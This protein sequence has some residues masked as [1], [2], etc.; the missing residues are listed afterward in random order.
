MNSFADLT[1]MLPILVESPDR[2]RNVR[3]V[4]P[5]LVHCCPDATFRIQ[6]YPS[7][8]TAKVQ[9]IVE[10]Q[11]AKGA[12]IIYELLEERTMFHRTR[13]LNEMLVATTTTL[14][15]NYDIDVLLPAWLY[16][17]VCILLRKGT[18]LVYPFGFVCPDGRSVLDATQ[19][20]QLFLQ[21]FRLDAF[22]NFKPGTTETGHASFFQTE[23]YRRMGGESE[24]Y[25][26][27]GPED[28]ERC[29]RAHRCGLKIQYLAGSTVFHLE[30]SRHATS[31]N[32]KGATRR[33]RLEEI[34]NTLH[35]LSPEEYA[36]WI[37]ITRDQLARTR[38][39]IVGSS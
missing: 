32:S 13:C 36:S 4:L 11:R 8:D 10:E 17:Y 24:L 39:K 5:Y 37:T 35:R 3:M 20:E 27:Y 7:D 14:V 23:A 22:T 38:R 33:Y 34:Y 26:C 21:E 31:G 30:H 6:E 15:V 2:L 12:N 19:K 25:C 18:E 1:F 16:D 28:R 9:K 29:L